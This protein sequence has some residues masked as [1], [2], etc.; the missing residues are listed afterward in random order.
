M[1]KNTDTRPMND[2]D[3][4]ETT[5]PAWPKRFT[6]RGI[7][8]AIDSPDDWPL[9]ALRAFER[10]NQIDALARVLGDAVWS[11]IEDM[12]ARETRELFDRVAEVAGFA[13]SG[14]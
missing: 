5:A 1:P 11:R 6:W 2:D 8:V 13:D 12:P 14:E 7:P 10:G 9:G 4:V 3:T